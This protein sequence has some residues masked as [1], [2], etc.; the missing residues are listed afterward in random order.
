MSGFER[1]IYLANL[2]G[3]RRRRRRWATSPSAAGGSS[4]GATRTTRR[5][6]ASRPTVAAGRLDTRH[7]A[8]AGGDRRPDRRRGRL[9]GPRRDG[10]VRRRRGAD[11]GGGRRRAGR[12]SAAMPWGVIVMVCGVT[13]LTALLEKTGGI[14]LFTTILGAVLDPRI[15]HRADRAVTG[16]VSVYSSTSGVVLPA[17]LP[18]VPGLVAEARRRRP[19]GDRLVDPDRRPPRRRLAALDDRRPLRRLA[20]VA[21]RPAAAVQ[22]GARL[23]AVDVGRRRA[24]LLRRL[25][26]VDDG[27]GFASR[28]SLD[29]ADS[30]SPIASPAC[31]RRPST[32]C[33]QRSGSSRP[34]AASLVSLMRGPARHA[35][36]AA[37]SSRPPIKALRD[38]RT[39]YP[40]NQG[41]PACAGPSPRSS[42]ATRA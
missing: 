3:Q 29:H 16:L 15:G 25:R 1:Q 4:A 31:G 10:G 19:A 5:P 41:E 17:F 39:G 11:P 28:V 42:G 33:L 18:S 27:G 14:D 26:T 20:P 6:T 38:G 8:H 36:A 40:D 35:H 23:G 30:R 22:P 24:G 21:A 2:A 9:R 37:T 12:R 13:V 34:R 32:G 7:V